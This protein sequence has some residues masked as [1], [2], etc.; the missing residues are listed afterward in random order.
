[1]KNILNINNINKQNKDLVG[2]KAYNL[3]FLA[4]RGINTAKFFVI[5]ADV[6][7]K[8]KQL[9]KEFNLPLDLQKDVLINLKKLEKDKVAVR[10]SANCEDQINSSFAGQFETYLGVFKDKIFDKIKQCWVSVFTE[11]VF[12]YC[13]FHQI[14]FS[15][16][17]M[18]VIIQEMIMAEKGGV[19]FTRDVF[20]HNKDKV[21]IETAKGL[22]EKV[23]SGLV[24]PQR[25]I[26][27]KE[28]KKCIEGAIG[29]E[30]QVLTLNEAEKLFK[31]ALKIEK[32]FG[33]PQD[34]EWAIE[35]NIIYILQSRP[36]M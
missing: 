7:D 12:T 23:V 4:N 34:I 3:S 22:G 31:I 10:S 2:G 30:K 19:I 13:N 24:N 32:I 33:Q 16:I 15:S 5:T 17:K 29:L 21:I 18:A 9:D 35:N 14:D 27:S 20:N 36:I 11:Q 28:K 1:M 26:F 6:F 8:V 25:M